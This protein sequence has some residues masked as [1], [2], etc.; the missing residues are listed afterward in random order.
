MSFTFKKRSVQRF[1]AA[2]SSLLYFSL[3]SASSL[4]FDSK[5]IATLSAMAL[6]KFISSLSH[7][8]IV[9]IVSIHTNPISSPLIKT[10]VLITEQTPGTSCLSGYNSF[11]IGLFFTFEA[12]SGVLFSKDKKKSG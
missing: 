5:E 12:T 6:E 3:C 8:L 10:G 2:S 9:A 7:C 4:F 11:I 1:I